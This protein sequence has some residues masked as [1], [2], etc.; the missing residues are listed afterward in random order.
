MVDSRNKGKVFE[1]LIAN[2]LRDVFNIPGARRGL[3]QSGGALEPDVTA[4]DG[5]W[6]FWTECKA[7]KQV[8]VQAAL[9][10]ADR[11]AGRKQIRSPVLVIGRETGGDIFFALR[12]SEREA[13]AEIFGCVITPGLICTPGLNVLGLTPH[14]S[15]RTFRKALAETHGGNVLLVEEDAIV[16]WIEELQT[17]WLSRS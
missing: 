4:D 7:M 2:R 8:N 14:K 17:L 1:R 6:P 3:T 5:A 11:D 16:G 9:R 13:W 12:W 15:W 10:Q